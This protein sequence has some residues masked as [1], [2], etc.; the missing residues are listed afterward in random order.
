MG[1]TR[2]FSSLR[3]DLNRIF[4]EMDREFFSTPALMSG[5]GQPEGAGGSALSVVW[6]PAMDICETEN[7]LLV[8]VS[9]PGLKSE[10]IQLEVE[11]DVL[12]IQGESRQESESQEK[13]FHRK[14]IVCG[15]FF[16]RVQLPVNVQGEQA[17][18][19]FENGI[20][21]IT[22]QKAQQARRH[23]IPIS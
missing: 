10:D 9:V 20:L 18:A 13:N 16:R 15:K 22:L 19:R 4:N 21:N 6:A 14:E 17:E 5:R 12:T 8:K 7:E 2:P 1:L 11:D 3:E 23:K